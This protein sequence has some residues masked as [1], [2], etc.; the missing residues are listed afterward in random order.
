MRRHADDAPNGG[1]R[2]LEGGR[3]MVPHNY[4]IPGCCIISFSTL[5]L[6]GEQSTVSH[7]APPFEWFKIEE[8]P[9][10][11]LHIESSLLAVSL[12]LASDLR[13]R[14][15]T[16]LTPPSRFATDTHTYTS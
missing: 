2:I 11:S 15:R 16:P 13:A 4:L 5:L 12:H 8:L 7:A 6:D 10:Y 3:R 9:C 1:S 14:G